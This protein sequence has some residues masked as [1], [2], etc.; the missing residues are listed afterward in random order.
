MT[1]G[2][3]QKLYL[4]TADRGVIQVCSRDITFS[5]VG[6]SADPKTALTV[7]SGHPVDILVADWLLLQSE[8]QMRWAS[9]LRRNSTSLILLE[10]TESAVISLRT[11][12]VAVTNCRGAD[13]LANCLEGL[14]I[15][16]DGASFG[17]G[18]IQGEGEEAFLDLSPL[19][20]VPPGRPQD[21]AFSAVASQPV[22]LTQRVV[23]VISPKGG[24]GK[25]VIAT[26]LAA[27]LASYLDK[28]VLL[29]DLDL[30]AGDIAVHLGF[31]RGPTVVDMLPFID[32]LEPGDLEGFLKVYDPVSLRALLAPGRPD[33]GALV[34]L[35]HINRI[36][37]WARRVFSVII[38]DLGTDLESEINR[39]C[40]QESTHWVVVTTSSPAC[41]RRVRLHLELTAS[42]A[43][44]G[45][46][47]VVV[48]RHSDSGL[49][50]PAQASRFLG[51]DIVVT[52]PEDHEVEKSVLY[53]KPHVLTP[54]RN[55][56]S[57]GF[58]RQITALAAEICP[59]N[60]SPPERRPSLI[61]RLSSLFNRY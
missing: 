48:N 7:L 31:N 1:S 34:Q 2:A 51:R 14:K 41:L 37:S 24:V 20:G 13:E 19:R 15:S 6:L 10:A 21:E 23:S 26:N 32:E 35:R 57:G 33:L 39:Y 22:V 27:L 29:W 9:Q 45:E 49:V 50:G 11:S 43:S 4:L 18:N 36:L 59:I 16:T 55:G 53:G 3:P 17:T 54:A 42:E 12:E 52:I 44:R 61:Q 60:Y 47:L 46:A 8:D 40:L 28:Q 56:A 58:A 30:A 38:L 25:T 5:L